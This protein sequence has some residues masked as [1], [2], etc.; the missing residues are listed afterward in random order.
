MF[1]HRYLNLFP[2]K[3]IEKEYKKLQQQVLTLQQHMEVL[4]KGISETVTDKWNQ[5][6]AYYLRWPKGNAF[7]FDGLNV[8]YN[9]QNEWATFILE[10]TK[11]KKYVDIATSIINLFVDNIKTDKHTLP[12]EAIW[13]YWWGKAWDGWTE[14]EQI[15]EHKKKY[16]GDKGNGW[17]SFRSIDAI[18][19]LALSLT[20]LNN[21]QYHKDIIQISKFMQNGK[22][23][24]FVSAK[25]HQHNIL[26][27]LKKEVISEYIRFTSPW[28]FDN[29]VWS[30]LNYIKQSTNLDYKN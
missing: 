19:V 7:Y 28:E 11:D 12:K 4:E 20:E 2:D 5:T 8:P 24:P 3:N 30:Y 17:I 23:Y 1:L 9:H 15:S 13:P 27:A 25:L 18:S 10:T 26:P 22:L 6:D 16:S 14:A 29:C 21:L